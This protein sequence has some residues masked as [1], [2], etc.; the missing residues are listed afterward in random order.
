MVV[1]NGL[2]ASLFKDNYRSDVVFFA[3]GVSNS[4]EKEDSQF[5]REKKLLKKTLREHLDKIF[6]Y[7]ST[8][9]IYDSSKNSS[10][11]VLHKLNMEQMVRDTAK[12][13]LVLRVSNAVGKGG[14][15]N[16][17][18]NYLMN[19]AQKELTINVHTRASRNL[20]DAEDIKNITEKLLAEAELNRIINIAFPQNYTDVEILEIIERFYHKKLDLNLV[21]KGSGYDIA[22]PETENYFKEKHLTSKEDY[23]MNILKKYYS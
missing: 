19:A 22:I 6:V 10:P 18:I 8:C 4:L 12:Q 17:L 13:Y 11:Y 1:G 15:T 20:I 2:M 23:L 5:E 9:S 16:L 14:N 3:S 7:F 21:K